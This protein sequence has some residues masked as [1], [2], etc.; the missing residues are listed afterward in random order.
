VYPLLK[1]VYGFLSGLSLER[2][3]SLGRILGSVAYC[4]LHNRRET[5]EKNCEVIGIPSDQIDDVVKSSFRHTFSA[6]MESFYTRN[7]DQKFLDE[8]VEV[9]YIDGTPEDRGCFMVS[10]H[11]GGWEL[12]PY[13]MTGK[14]GLKGAVVARKIKDKKVD[15]FIKA[16]RINASADYIHHRNATETIKEYL[17]KGLSVGVLLDHSSMPKDSMAVPFFGLN[18]T[19]IKGIPLLAVRR[20]YPILT[21]FIIRK[22][23]GFKMIVYPY[24]YPDKTL[25]PKERAHDLALKINGRFE[26]VIRK[27]PDQWYL[28]HKRF[29]RLIDKDGN[30]INGIYS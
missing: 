14:L 3:Q 2:L 15:E 5:A 19:F 16:Q 22:N 7:I 25:K 24:I 12:A 29:K 1:L 9:E 21:A 13:V 17:D 8:K 10:A 11:F 20:N 4:T 26:E 18:T 6:Y 30:Y 27:Y 23:D 28:I